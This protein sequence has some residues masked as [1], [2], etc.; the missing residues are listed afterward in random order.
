MLLFAGPTGTGKTELAKALAE[1]LFGSEASLLRF[2]M[3]EYMEEH[4]VSKLIGSPPGYI[5]HDEGGRLTDAVRARPYSVILFDE[6]EKAHPRVLDLFL[7]IFD[8]GTL[9]D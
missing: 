6:V 4:S 5:G 9:T 8:K 3:S 1:F 2:D 7:Q